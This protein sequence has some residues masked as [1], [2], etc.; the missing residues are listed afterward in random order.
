MNESNPNED[1]SRRFDFRIYAE[2]VYKGK[3]DK[4]RRGQKHLV[5]TTEQHDNNERK[6]IIFEEYLRIENKLESANTDIVIV[7]IAVVIILPFF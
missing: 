7:V 2:W 4:Q 3:Q 1:K 5:D 6:K